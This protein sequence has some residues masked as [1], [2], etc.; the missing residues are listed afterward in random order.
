MAVK[1]LKGWKG[2]EMMSVSVCASNGRSNCLKYI[3]G[4][5]PTKGGC[6]NP[7]VKL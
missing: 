7:L 1:G 2:V 3:R 4:E 5:L 6:N